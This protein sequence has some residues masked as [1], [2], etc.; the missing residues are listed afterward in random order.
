[1]TSSY[2]DEDKDEEFVQ[3]SI[4]DATPVVNASDFSI[5]AYLNENG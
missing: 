4:A 2:D 3:D 5:S 1:L